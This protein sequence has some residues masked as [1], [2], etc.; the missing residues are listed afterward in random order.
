MEGPRAGD[1]WLS[2]GDVFEI[3]PNGYYRIVDRIKDIYK[4]TRG[5]TVAPLKVE[6]K[7]AG[8]PGI[9]RTF[10]VGDGRPHNVLFHRPG[11]RRCR[12]AG[13]LDAD[14]EREYYRRIVGAA[15]LDLAPYERVVHFAVLDRDS[16]K[17]GAS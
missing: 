13:G 15:N 17:P 5:E 7:F 16:R 8:V 2:T 9:K 3:L 6:S 14:G 12:P 10:L 4:N 11:L 1:E